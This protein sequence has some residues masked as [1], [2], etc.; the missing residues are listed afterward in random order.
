MQNDVGTWEL[1][2]TTSFKIILSKVRKM[3]ISHKQELR[4]CFYLLRNYHQ[5]NIKMMRTFQALY[6]I[7]VGLVELCDYLANDLDA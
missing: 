5:K 1:F 7:C 2:H 3:Y 6:Y 4:L